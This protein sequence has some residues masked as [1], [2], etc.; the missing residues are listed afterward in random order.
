[1]SNQYD[2][3]NV[4]TMEML[5][6]EGYLSMGG[7]DEVAKIV[8]TVKLDGLDVLD[9]GCGLGGASITLAREYH[10]RVCGIDIDAAVLE[11]ANELV[12]KAN[13]QQQVKLLRFDPGPLPF[14]D[15]SFDVVYLTAVSCH[16]EDLSPF[17][18]EIK[19][20]I[21]PGGCLLGGEWFKA[22]E[23]E[24]YQQWDEML[25]GRGLNFYFVTLDGLRQ[26]FTKV[27]F[28]AVSVHDQSQRVAALAEQYLQRVKLELRQ[29]LLDSMSPEEY[30]DLIDWTRIR[31]RGL[32]QGGSGYAHFLAWVA[33]SAD[34][35]N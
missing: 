8:S 31:A 25:R 28:E 18:A 13:L 20:I 21:R 1:M 5:Y 9:I 3:R 6:G 23:N 19:R 4:Q 11:R 27:G 34:R 26:A 17:L 10:G 29:E 15:Q 33:E 24:A 22:S 35:D 12:E 30:S 7:D 16:I 14:A 2:K 32:V